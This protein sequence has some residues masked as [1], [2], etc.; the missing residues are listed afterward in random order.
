M[1]I[2]LPFTP[3]WTREYIEKTLSRKYYKKPYDRFKWWRGYTSINKPLSSRVALKERILNGDF[4]PGPYLMEVELVLHT[5]ND[6]YRAALTTQNDFDH[7]V[8]TEATSVDRARKKRLLED[9]E[10]EEF[11]KLTDLREEFT[12]VFKLTKDQYD[13][14]VVESTGKIID[15]YYEMESKYG[16]YI[17][18]PRR[19]LK[20][21][22]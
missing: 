13:I 1:E 5:M 16:K 19:A 6:K 10:K 21:K 7:G 4:E 8:Y 3:K 22:A 12:T 2:Q 14:E 18:I 15:F 17:Q 9:H 20:N 11:R